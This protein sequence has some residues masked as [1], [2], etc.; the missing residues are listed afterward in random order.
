[1]LTKQ[2]RCGDIDQ[3]WHLNYQN[4]SQLIQLKMQDILL[5]LP[6]QRYSK[7]GHL[8]IQKKPDLFIFLHESSRAERV[9]SDESFWVNAVSRKTFFLL[10][11]ELGMLPNENSPSSGGQLFIMICCS[12]FNKTKANNSTRSMSW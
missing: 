3:L 1:M 6:I 12:G 7:K 4:T 2:L 11:Y 10:F 8:K 9:V 5:Y